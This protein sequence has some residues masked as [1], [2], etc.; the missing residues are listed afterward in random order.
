MREAFNKLLTE[1]QTQSKIPFKPTENN[2]AK[3]ILNEVP[4][5]IIKDVLMENIERYK[6]Q[7]SVGQG[8]W[9]ETPWISIFDRSIT[10]TATKGFYIVYLFR[11]DMEGV[12]LSLNQG[13]TYL[14]NKYKGKKPRDK[15]TKVAERLR[16]VIDYS[17]EDFPLE[18]IDLKSTTGNAKNYSAAHVCGKY[19]FADNLPSDEELRED[20]INLLGVYNKLKFLMGLKSTD[21]FID[22]LLTLDEIEDTQYQSDIQSVLPSN[23]PQTPRLIPPQENTGAGKRWKRD[24]AIAKEALKKVNYVC[25]ID[26]S[27]KT[28]V[29]EVSGENFVEAHHL[30]PMSL[31]SNFP[32]SL[33][34]PGNI[35]SLCP[36]CHRKIHHAV[37]SEK[38]QIIEDLYLQRKGVLSSFGI[39]I[40]LEHLIKAYC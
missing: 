33:D 2:F 11:K 9:T 19:Y 18:E 13:T 29:S 7:A 17:L 26:P 35:V 16:S 23:T 40:S 14:Q 30:I 20:L 31:Q 27:H 28:F 24:A 8:N 39:D 32:W 25:E 6:V 34:V 1:Y 38:L 36:N 37:K 15:M 21:Q 5:I 10:E 22:F 12:Y 4:D 3:Y